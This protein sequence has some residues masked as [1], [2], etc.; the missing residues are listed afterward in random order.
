MTMKPP[1]LRK[2][3]ILYAPHHAP[4]ATA[5]THKASMSSS[6]PCAPSYPAM[7]ARFPINQARTKIHHDT[8]G[9]SALAGRTFT[10][11]ASHLLGGWAQPLA[12]AF[13]GDGR[14]THYEILPH[15]DKRQLSA[16]PLI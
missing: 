13:H 8:R 6:N 16:W 12:L 11:T 3:E 9:R 5:K 14:S 1:R 7:R 15:G 2:L 4:H 10:D